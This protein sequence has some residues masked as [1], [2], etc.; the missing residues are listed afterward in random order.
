MIQSSELII[1][2]DGSIFH[3]HLKPKQLADNVILVGDPGRVELIGKLLTDIEFPYVDS[4]I[5]WARR[6]FQ[7]KVSAL[8]AAK[9]FDYQENPEEW[10][11]VDFRETIGLVSGTSIAI[12]V[13]ILFRCNLSDSN[14]QASEDVLDKEEDIRDA[15]C[16]FF[17]K[18]EEIRC[19]SEDKECNSHCDVSDFKAPID[20]K[21]C[22]K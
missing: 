4:K 10:L 19:T 17:K 5:D 7:D 20:E 9:D 21:D 12:V 13:S 6:N 3:L 11:E 1:N 16:K 8:D 15:R 22:T 14:D 2:A 18:H